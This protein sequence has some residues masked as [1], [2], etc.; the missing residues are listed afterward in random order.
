M[1]ESNKQVLISYNW[2]QKDKA[3][4]I[5]NYLRSKNVLVWIDMELMEEKASEKV[6]EAIEESSVILVF[7]SSKYQ[8]S[9]VCKRE[10]EYAVK[11]QKDIIW[12]LAEENYKPNGWLGMLIGNK[13]S[14]NP[15]KNELFNEQLFLPIIS[16]ITKFFNQPQTSVPQIQE[17]EQGEKKK[18]IES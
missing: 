9:Q 2:T 13:S 11:E 4:T 1:E 8:D 14:Y 17:K 5:S 16:Q 10:I 7:L 6:A 12:I 15:W 3:K 18:K